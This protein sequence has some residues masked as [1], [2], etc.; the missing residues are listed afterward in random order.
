MRQIALAIALALA[1]FA[2]LAASLGVP[3]DQSIRITMPVPFRD[4]IIGNP[5][6]ADV[7]VADNRH[8]V[9]T[10]KTGGVTNLIVTDAA[11]HTIFD[12][13]LVV[14]GSSGDHVVL[15]NGAEVVNYACAPG[16]ALV[17]SAA[18]GG[19]AVTAAIGAPTTSVTAPA[20]QTTS[21]PPPSPMLP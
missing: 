13:Q 1:P 18:G 15:I 3:L 20:P 12:R 7:A 9:V 11:G 10:G 5:A 21:L 16:C 14:S 6:I 2:A 8:L 19:G 4:V 17:A